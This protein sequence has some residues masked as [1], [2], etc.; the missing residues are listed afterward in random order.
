M[1]GAERFKRLFPEAILQ[2]GL[3]VHMLVRHKENADLA[4]ERWEEFGV[5]Y[6]LKSSSE[7]S[8]RY[9]TLDT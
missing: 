5:E 9:P 1:V 7:L 2:Q 4:L 6:K 8:V 3:P